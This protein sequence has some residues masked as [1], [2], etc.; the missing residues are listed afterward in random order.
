MPIKP[1][2]WP[3]TLR[4][5]RAKYR[6]SRAELAATLAGIPL[7]TVESWENAERTPPPYLRLALEVVAARI[8]SRRSRT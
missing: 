6:L 5:F 3:A 1:E 7:R 4:A 2:N 8:A